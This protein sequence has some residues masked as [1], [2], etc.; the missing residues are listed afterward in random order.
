MDGYRNSNNVFSYPERIGREDRDWQGRWW[1]RA[2][3]GF[4]G[5]EQPFNL[6][7]TDRLRPA[8]VSHFT[9][10]WYANAGEET[11]AISPR[12]LATC[13]VLSVAVQ[14][15]DRV[16]IRTRSNITN[17][18][19]LTRWIGF[20]TQLET[21]G[22]T[23]TRIVASSLVQKFV[24]DQ[25]EKNKVVSKFYVTFNLRLIFIFIPFCFA[26]GKTRRTNET[27]QTNPLTTR[28]GVDFHAVKT[29]SPTLL[30]FHAANYL[31]KSRAHRSSC[32]SAV[33]VNTEH[34]MIYDRC[35]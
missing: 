20:P 6:R 31:T 11:C 5:R 8:I 24:I 22:N 34:V 7:S 30:V 32:I 18:F 33:S 15:R 3:K 2:R 25:S 27:R 16:P 12:R 21:R 1:N 9:G 14:V 35:V 19:T 17:S 4:A 26:A 13:Q 23:F 29:R 10:L 28:R